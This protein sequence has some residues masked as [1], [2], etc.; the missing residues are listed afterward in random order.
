MRTHRCDESQKLADMALA[1]WA[2]PKA[3]ARRARQRASAYMERAHKEPIKEL[4]DLGKEIGKYGAPF[5]L[6]TYLIA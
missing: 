2:Q 3:S 4:Y 5:S 6:L 1:P